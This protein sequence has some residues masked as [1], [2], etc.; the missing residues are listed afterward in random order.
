MFEKGFGVLAPSLA[1]SVG[2]TVCFPPSSTISNS[3]LVLQIIK[4]Q[5]ITSLMTVPTIL[6][7]VVLSSAAKSLASLDFVVVG[8]GP[9]KHAVAE[10]LHSNNVKLL[11]HFGA[12]ELGA[13][14]PIFR[15]NQSYDWRY[16]RLRTDL[17]LELKQIETPT[18]ADTAYKLYG[19]PFG[20]RVDYEL[21]DN[22][23]INPL[24][25]RNEV[26]LTGRKDDLIVLATGEKVTPHLMEDHLEQDLRIKRAVVFG[27]GQFEVGVLLEPA[28]ATVGSEKNFVESIWP[29][30]LE[31][32]DK[33]DKHACITTKAAVLVKPSG[34]SIPLSD[35]GSSQRKD[36]YSLFDF[37]IRSVYERMEK[38]MPGT[39]A[40]FIDPED[41][42]GSL[43]EIL[44]SCLPPHIKSDAWKDNDDFI[45]LGMDSLQATRLRRILDRLFRQSKR[46]TKHSKGLPLDFVY[47]HSSILRLVEAFEDPEGVRGYSVSETKL[48]RDLSDKFSFQNRK[49]SFLTNTNTILLTG[50][51]GNLGS[52]LLK[53]LSE[54]P[55]VP[56]VV[57]LVR[58]TSNRS[59]SCL[60]KDAMSGQRKAFDDRGIKLSEEAWSKVKFLAWQPGDDRLGLGEDEYYNLASAITHIFHGAWPMDFQRKLSSFEVHI[61]A[62]RDLVTLARLA[63]SLRPNLK[64]R[65]IFASSVAVV[66]NCAATTGLMGMIPEIPLHDPTNAPLAMGYA[67]AKWICEQV[68]ESAYN[69]LKHE[70]QPIIVRIGQ[71]T[72]SQTC[73]FWSVKEHVPALVKSSLFIGHFPD[74]RGV[75]NFRKTVPLQSQADP[76]LDTI[77]ASRR[78]S[79]TCDHR[80]SPSM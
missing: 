45:Q 52:H 64:P 7:D 67:Q 23:E 27:N 36:V 16:L 61:R 68:M 48:M 57:C 77:V 8:G 63:H 13:L 5:N 31:A 49:G 55:Q 76:I 30:I 3:A 73:G 43:R 51:T 20:S 62:V 60:L 40:V 50:T 4:A 39:S 65:I 1:L 59:P 35:K 29:V 6:E 28:S 66:G 2:K 69:E 53:I 34:K 80:P 14:A 15:P 26:K 17:G 18:G 33:V 38:D 25:P 10:N 41:P 21:Q 56:L 78:P 79:S 24:N 46:V 70:V 11:N 54:H 75:S 12:T 32:N 19:R 74:L 47:S 37:E 9:I 58:A 72:G 71:L 22:V 42:R 44:Q